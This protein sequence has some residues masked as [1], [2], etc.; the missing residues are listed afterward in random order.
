M[1]PEPRTL[2]DWRGNPYTVGT[3]IFYPRMSGRSCEMVEAVVVEIYDAVRDSD[4]YRWVRFDPDNP[5]HQA[6][7]KGDRVTRVVVQPTGLGSRDFFRSHTRLARD[8]AGEMVRDEQGGPVWETTE[9]KPVTLM[10]TNNVTVPAPRAGRA[11][12]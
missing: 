5:R 9:I 2:T 8:E 3:L 1:S 11:D 12:A 10:I 4:K 7:S 6:T